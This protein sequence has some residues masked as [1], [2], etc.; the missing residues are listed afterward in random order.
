[1]HAS[2][3]CRLPAGVCRLGAPRR[4]SRPSRQGF[5]AESA[6]NGRRGEGAA[7]RL[8]RRQQE[9]AA[10]A[11]AKQ[12]ELSF[13]GVRSGTSMLRYKCSACKSFT[14]AANTSRQ[15]GHPPARMLGLSRSAGLQ[16]AS[17]AL[18]G[19]APVPQ[20]ASGSRP[21]GGG[22]AAVRGREEGQLGAGQTQG[23]RAG[24]GKRCLR[25]RCRWRRRQT[26]QLTNATAAPMVA[27]V[28]SL[29]LKQ[30]NGSSSQPSTSVAC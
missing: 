17:P 19:T 1:M 11:V 2:A 4:S 12:P 18:R 9:T 10:Q 5:P 22:S 15:V 8:S 20:T 28:L 24:K 7:G 27:W 21:S 14:A 26:P 6:A 3:P 13:M 23:S 16:D 25:E 30:H 29:L